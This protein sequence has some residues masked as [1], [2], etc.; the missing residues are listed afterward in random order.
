MNQPQSEDEHSEIEFYYPF[1]LF[2]SNA[3]EAHS[4]SHYI[5]MVSKNAIIIINLLL[6]LSAWS[7][8]ENIR[9]RSFMYGPLPTG[10]IRTVK[11]LVWYFPVMTVLS[12]NKKLIIAK[13]KKDWSVFS[14]RVWFCG[15]NTLPMKHS[16]FM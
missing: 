14:V 4:L 13:Y 10:L 9:P 16:S 1:S 6:T 5:C 15:Y 12:V 2:C 3:C 11:T 8:R 7:L